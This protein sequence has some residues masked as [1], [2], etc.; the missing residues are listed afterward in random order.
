MEQYINCPEDKKNYDF[1]KR[2]RAR[3]HHELAR[4]YC[5]RNSVPALSEKQKECIRQY[6]KQY[7]I[8]VNDFSWH[9]MYY[10]VTGS[11]DPRFVPDAIAG[12]IVYEFYNDH[13]YEYTWR[14]KNMFDRLLP[15]V[16]LP[17][18]Y[19]KCCRN[20]MQIQGKIYIFNDQNI[21]GIARNMFGLVQA[22]EDS[23]TIIFKPTRHS[24]FGRGV[25]KYQVKDINDLK[26]A[27]EEWRGETD[28]IVQE[29]IQQHEILAS[30]NETSTNMIRVC[31]WRHGDKVDILFA[32]ARIGLPGATTD[33]SFINGVEQARVVGITRD[34]LFKEHVVDQEGKIVR[35]IPSDIKVPAWNKIVSIIKENH[36]QVDNFDIIGWDFTVNKASNPVC[37]EWNIQWPGT[38]L[39]Q[40][41]NGPLWGELTDDILQFL[42]DKKNQDNYVPCYMR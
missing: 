21:L 1:I 38:V 13:A 15:G 11:E 35:R 41:V 24:G 40:Y 27:L 14:D 2:G 17:K 6:W 19:A 37:F 12:H 18:S 39:Y 5:E 34:G 8:S 7:G 26:T 16:P 33:I 3:I 31:S 30:F 28:F 29:C 20:R 9:Q 4:E 36:L 25:K 32:A 10:Y 22:D 42:K 23:D